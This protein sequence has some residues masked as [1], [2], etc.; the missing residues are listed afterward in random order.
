LRAFDTKPWANARPPGARSSWSYGR[1]AASQHP[2]PEVQQVGDADELQRAV[3][4]GRG[5]EQ[6]RDAERGGGGVQRQP[7]RAAEHRPQP[8]GPAADQGVARDQGLIGAGERDQRQ[9]CE[10]EFDRHSDMSAHGI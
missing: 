4:G 5:G 1:W 10:G 9:R 6:R 2:H 7:A 8:G 3:G